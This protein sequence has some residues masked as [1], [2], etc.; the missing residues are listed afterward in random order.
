MAVKLPNDKLVSLPIKRTRWATQRIPDPRA[1]A[2]RH[3]IMSRFH[4][5]AGAEEKTKESVDGTQTAEHGVL[6]P[7]DSDGSDEEGGSVGHRRIFVNIPLPADAKDEDGRPISHFGR[8]KIRTAKY[9]PLSFVPKNLW[10]QFHNVANI[11]F[12]F[13]DIL[14]VSDCYQLQFFLRFNTCHTDLLNIWCDK[15]GPQCGTTHRH[16]IHHGGQGWN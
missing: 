13:I 2:K 6:E 15:P 14:S 4:K 3:G 11:Y 8:N 7:A 10:Y 12:L 16:P 1:Q 5:N 9:T